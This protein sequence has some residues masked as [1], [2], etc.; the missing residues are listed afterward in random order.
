MWSPL[1]SN[2][3]WWKTFSVKSICKILLFAVTLVTA[4][5]YCQA[6][7]IVVKASVDTA[8]YVIGDWIPVSLEAVH[9]DNIIVFPPDLGEKAGDLDV[10]KL[11]SFQPEQN[12]ES[13]R[14]KWRLV[15]AAY[16]TGT[17]SVPPI[18]L[19]YHEAGD[20]VINAVQTDPFDIRIYSAGGDTIAAP[21]DIKPPVSAP[22]A[23]ADYLPYIIA[24]L[25]AAILILAF[26]WWK[27]WRKRPVAVAETPPIEIEI[28]PFD[29]AMKRFV[30]LKN[31]KLWQSGYV[32]EY[33]S[34]VTEIVREYVEGA[35]KILALEMTTDE[36]F[37]AVKNLDILQEIEFRKLFIDADL[38]KFA[39]LIPDAE[40]CN[41][42]LT[43]AE[44]IVKQAN[45]KRC[46]TQIPEP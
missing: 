4:G 32:K 33:W 13:I 1:I 36:L 39:K 17:F 31:R 6:A 8:E 40:M 25:S 2:Y 44:E 11:Y 34:E 5:R 37:Q 12:K 46:N 9:A 20:T 15:L 14:V 27:K 21:H 35:F 30:D 23:F 41:K 26:L 22:L 28:D 7:E 29:N 18:E 43:I 16:D 42:A 3:S 38:V 10:V 19:Q 24:G 45:T